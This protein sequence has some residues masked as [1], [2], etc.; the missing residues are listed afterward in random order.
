MGQMESPEL[1]LSQ[2]PSHEPTLLVRRAQLGSA[3]AFEELVHL[4][5]QH[6]YRF[7]ALRLADESD[8]RDA[9]QETLVAA[10]QGLPALKRP[11]SFWPWLAGIAAHKAADAVRKRPPAGGDAELVSVETAETVEIRRALA[12]LPTHFREILL[13]RHVLGLSEQET[14]LALGVRLGTVKSRTSRA[15]RALEKLLR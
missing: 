8:A 11:E 2:P 15:R 5:G 1:A 4:Y 3:A 10:W 9:L 13:L 7:L 6:L 14:A 12:S